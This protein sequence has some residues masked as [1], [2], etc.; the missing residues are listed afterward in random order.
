[1]AGESKVWIAFICLVGV[2]VVGSGFLIWSDGNHRANESNHKAALRNAACANPD[3][4][5]CALAVRQ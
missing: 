5:A 2:V 4:V 1:M 3:S